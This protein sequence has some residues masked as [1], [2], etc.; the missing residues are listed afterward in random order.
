MSDGGIIRIG[1]G[2]SEYSRDQSFLSIRQYESSDGDSRQDS[3]SSMAM[4]D[5]KRNNSNWDATSDYS[6]GNIIQIGGDANSSFQS[7]AMSETSIRQI[8]ASQ[9]KGF[10][11]R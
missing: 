7:S 5:I 6:D 11:A 8:G 9:H 1:G 10:G 4:T 2:G 3:D